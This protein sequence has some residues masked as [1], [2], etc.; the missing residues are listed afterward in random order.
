MER[1]IQYAPTEIIF[2]KD[3]ELQ[4]GSAVKK[5]GG[6]RVLIVYGT[7]SV[8]KSG[9]LDKVKKSLELEGI[10][11]EELGG[12]QPNPRLQFA[13]DGTK[14]AREMN[15]DFILAVGGGSAI[16][17]AKGI[18]LSNPN[19]ELDMWE[20]IWL[21]KATLTKST[22]VGVILTISAAGSETSESAVLT[23]E[24]T[25]R[26]KGLSVSFNRPKFAIMNPELTYTIPR[27]Q[28]SCG[29]VDIMMHT[30]DRYFTPVQGNELTDQIAESLL[31]VTIASGKVAFENQRDYQAMSEL[32]WAGSLSHNGTTGLG[33]EGDFATHVLGH[34]LSAKYNTYHGESLSVVWPSWARYV[35]KTDMKRF[36]RY[37]KEVWN[38]TEG[39]DD[40]RA[41]AG[42]EAT[43]A[44]FKSIQLPISF[45][46]LENG[47]RPDTQLLEL[48]QGATLK[49]TI[50]VGSF[51]KLDE[52]AAYAI[53]KGANY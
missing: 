44:F 7:G 11:T 26:K 49:N 36:V 10:Y 4:V 15:A 35:Y 53:Y 25:G 19:P 41:M 18:A 6:S 30:L 39:T 13:I 2:G 51:M 47:V 20:D 21:A 40:E 43:E 45:G 12:V 24:T 17:T 52:D 9:L 3:T 8:V 34:E 37:A 14:K 5:W 48:A 33:G 23:N 42:I 1:F 29:I 31:R 28:L 27:R 16:D 22:P 38:I 46:D 32:M 50:Q